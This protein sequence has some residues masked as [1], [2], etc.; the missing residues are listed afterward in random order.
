MVL[1]KVNE[2]FDFIADTACQFSNLLSS[3]GAALDSHRPNAS[4]CS[5][6]EDLELQI[7]KLLV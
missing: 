4:W 2:R 7:R 6:L 3:T 1:P 5:E